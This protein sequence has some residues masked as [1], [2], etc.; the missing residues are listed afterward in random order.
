MGWGQSGWGRS[1]DGLGGRFGGNRSG[2]GVVVAAAVGRGAC[3]DRP[4]D[5]D[6]ALLSLKNAILSCNC[7]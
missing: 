5:I 3:D 2:V 1:G 4:V 7:C 6:R